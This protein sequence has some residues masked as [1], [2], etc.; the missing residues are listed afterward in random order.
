ME[1][2]RA[3]TAGC[4][5]CVL[6]FPLLAFVESESTGMWLELMRF[7]ST[8]FFGSWMASDAMESDESSRITS[9]ARRV[10]TTELLRRFSFASCGGGLASCCGEP[11]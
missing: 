1:C 7:V 3:I 8:R 11:P 5:K 6:T 4:W 10:D 9:D 2:L